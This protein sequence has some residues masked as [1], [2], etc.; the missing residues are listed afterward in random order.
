M[1]PDGVL[2]GQPYFLWLDVDEEKQEEKIQLAC[3]TTKGGEGRGQQHITNLIHNMEGASSPSHSSKH[4]SIIKPASQINLLLHKPDIVCIT[5]S[6][7][8]VDIRWQWGFTIH[9]FQAQRLDHTTC[10]NGGGIVLYVLYYLSCTTLLQ[11]GHTVTPAVAVLFIIH[12]H[13]KTVTI[14]IILVQPCRYLI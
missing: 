7:F 10:S 12:H 2:M 5:E 14:L 9:G 13:P 1:Y 6:W 11:G 3:K 8:S 4:L